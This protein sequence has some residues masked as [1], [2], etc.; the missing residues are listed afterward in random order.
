MVLKVLLMAL[1]VYIPN[2]LHFPQSL[3]IKGFN[4]FNLLLLITIVA[5]VSSQRESSTPAPLKGRFLAYYVILAM[6]LITA[7]LQGTHHL[8]DDITAL[9]TAVAYSVLY[10]VAY[11]GVQDRE[12]I[13]KLVWVILVVV[14]LMGLE[15]FREAAAVGFNPQKRM[16]GAFGDSVF[17][18]NYAAIFLEILIPVAVAVLLFGSG[19]RKVRLAAAAAVI[20]G[21]LGVFFTQ[22][23]TAL[24]S[25]AVTTLA[26]ALLRSK[27]MA[28]LVV[29]AIVNYAAWVP[30]SVHQRVASTKQVDE[31][32]MER[33]DESTESRTVIWEAAWELIKDYPMG[34]GLN[35]FRDRID[36]FMPDWIKARDAHNH[37]I[38]ITTESGWIGGAVLV[39]LLFG[40]LG[41]GARL[42]RMSGDDK[43][44][45]VLALG[46]MGAWAGVIMGNL[47]HS[48]IYAGEVMGLFWILSGL[49]ARY[50]V[51]LQEE[52]S[53][54]AQE[55]AQTQQ[56]GVPPRRRTAAS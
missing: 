5:V 23:R 8:I 7:V 20:F 12:T 54:K 27:A 11:H 39:F 17:A 56:W 52:S 18:A 15:I 3:G 9:K 45:K 49:V 29:V 16:A 1:I 6:S 41:L 37:F 26:L 46:Y 38:L 51:I 10:F 50:S 44:A 21:V 2:A 35:Q 4:V 31:Y 43:D 24:A 48:V 30:E 28:A 42:Y 47:T 40:L 19:A 13:Q 33:F 36:P 55:L 25:V 34:V 14:F 32:G 22:S 53:A